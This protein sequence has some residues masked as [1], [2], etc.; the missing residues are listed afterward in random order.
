MP[1]QPGGGDP[2]HGA[3]AS[4]GR[5]IDSQDWNVVGHG[6]PPWFSDIMPGR[7]WREP[8]NAYSQEAKGLNLKGKTR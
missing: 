7:P 3:F 5:A 8:A 6:Q 4:T 1:S 2:A